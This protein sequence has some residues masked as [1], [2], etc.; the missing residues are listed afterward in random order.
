[1]LESKN[2]NVE[3]ISSPFDRLSARPNIDT[4]IVLLIGGEAMLTFSVW[5]VTYVHWCVSCRY[6]FLFIHLF[7]A[8]CRLLYTVFNICRKYATVWFPLLLVQ[9]PYMYAYAMTITTTQ[10]ALHVNNRVHTQQ[11]IICAARTDYAQKWVSYSY[12][13]TNHDHCIMCIKSDTY[14]YSG[15]IRV[16][17]KYSDAPAD[18]FFP[19]NNSI[20]HRRAT[21]RSLKVT[22]STFA[23]TGATWSLKTPKF[24]LG[25][26]RP[27][28]T[29]TTP[30]MAERKYTML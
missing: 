11:V 2:F 12:S 8:A 24:S 17:K 29:T 28:T 10:L 13:T 14:Y 23:R 9:V 4:V 19:W 7:D 5:A 20:L 27:K 25:T 16:V 21:H 3:Y 26:W 1:M 6:S 30:T 18:S 22:L 15:T